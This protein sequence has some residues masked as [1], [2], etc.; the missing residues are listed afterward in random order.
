MTTPKRILYVHYGDNWIRGSEVVLL[1]LISGIDR[2]K[3]E[4]FVWSNC[5]PLIDKCQSLGVEAEHSVFNL[6]G[7]WS[8]PRWDI[9]GWNSLIKQGSALIEKHNIDL[10]HVNSGGPCQWMC[11]A[12]RMNHIPLVTQLHCHYTL[13]DRFSLGLHLSPKLICV[14]KDVG[15]EIIQDGY[16][17][18]QLYVVHN[19]VSL[20]DSD[21]PIDIKTHLGIPPQ[22]FTFLSVGSLI[23][24]K[25]FD[26]LIRAMR[27]HN[28]HHD[29][30][31]LVIVGD[32][33][34]RETLQQLASDLGIQDRVHFVG[35]KSNAGAWMSGNADAFISGA[36]EEAFGLVLGEAALAQLPI[37]APKTGGI[38][39]LF[40]HNHSALLYQNRGMASLLNAIQ[41]V[42]QDAA[43]RNKLAENAYLHASQNLTTAASISAIERI[44][45]GELENNSITPMPMTHCMKPLSR[46]LSIN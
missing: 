4:P 33:E 44:Y 22:A 40:E 28:Y 38:P 9:S 34:E 31:H 19:G 7:G 12:A 25:G 6:V 26:R 24:R 43:L 41:Q 23:K 27:M 42:M 32:G 29:N 30:P 13:R 10:V 46:W 16:P 15:R 36:Y 3:F 5:Q 20:Q 8:A 39:E 14:S 11:L 18:D 37:V 21:T 45:E 17:E 2:D 1:D 35:E